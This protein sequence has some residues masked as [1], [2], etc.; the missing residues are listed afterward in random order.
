MNTAAAAD[1][2][3][4]CLACGASDLSLVETITAGDIAEGWRREDLAT[5]QTALADL[6]AR[7]L[8]RRLPAKIRFDR[9]Q[10]CGLE[11]ASPFIVWVSDEYPQ[12][13]SYPVR[14]EFYECLRELGP[15]P[16]DV[17]EL[18]CGP[19]E[20]LALATERGHRTVGIDFSPTA[21]GRARER[22]FAAFE[23]TL[24]QLA[25]HVPPGTRFDAVVF[26]QVIEH[27]SAP[28]ALFE[29]IARWMRPAG[30]LFL[31]CP[32]PR[33]YTRLIEEQRSGSSDF[34]DYPPHHVLRWTLPALR[35]FAARHGWRPSSAKEEPL[36]WVGAASHIGVARAIRRGL[37]D[38]PL[39]RRLTIAGAWASL[40]T[41]PPDRRAGTS[42]YFSAAR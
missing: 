36:S 22:G 31:S 28:D 2:P 24:D 13:Q 40:L 25:Q 17:L 42:L 3:A 12:D 30:R 29:T 9:C 15:A 38:R 11:M 7:T 27:L 14:W 35:L 10:R 23:G 20:F 5:G 41:A 16:I 18:G 4:R 8:L 39:R 1:T 34:W 21:I 32:G 26:F 37:L 19:G 33:R 6:R